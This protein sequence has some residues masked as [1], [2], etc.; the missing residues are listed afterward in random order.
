[1]L[2]PAVTARARTP[3]ALAGLQAAVTLSWMAYGYHQP[4]LLARFGFETLAGILGWYLALAGTTL[5]PLAG[6]ASDRLVRSGGDRLPIVRAG[7]ALAGA[8]FLAVALTAGAH[9]DSGV[10]FVLPLFVAVWIAGMTV[11]QAPALAIL[12]DGSGPAD[13]GSAM[14]PV[15][16]ATT[17]PMALWPWVETLLERAGGS[18]T[19]LA[20]G[21]AVVGTAV[22]VGRTAV[23]GDAR[24]TPGDAAS[25]PPG[26]AFACGVASAAVV[27]LATELVPAALA[28][29]AGLGPSSLAALATMAASLAVFAAARIG[30]TFGSGPA[31]VLGLSVAAAGR[32]A[33]A[34]V[35][36]P[37]G[38]LAVVAVT[39]LGLG[40]HLATALPFA[41]ARASSGRAGLS[42]GLYVGGAMLGS[43]VVR[44]LFAG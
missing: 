14:V 26:R 44:S 13:L 33:V 1:L 25:P 11:F 10:R 22:A 19:F 27:V 4:R 41:L 36:G 31:L 24:P 2:T 16:L 43:Q 34:A 17:L 9:A 35:G 39:G 28:H 3:W 23:L 8:S 21:L 20:G 7:V 5:A 38:A 42:T 18:L 6:D 37:V 40:L 30:R 12:R 15:V 29:R 32:A